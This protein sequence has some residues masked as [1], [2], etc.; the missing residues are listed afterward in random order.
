MRIFIGKKKLHWGEKSLDVRIDSTG[1][2]RTLKV[3][4]VK[5]GTTGRTIL[6]IPRGKNS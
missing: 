6:R 5:L 3:K 4:N 1:A 2:R